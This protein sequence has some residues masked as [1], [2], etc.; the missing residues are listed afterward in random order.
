MAAGGA[1]ALA[2]CQPPRPPMLC[3]NRGGRAGSSSSS[4]RSY[5][6]A[7]WRRSKPWVGQLPPGWPAVRRSNKSRR[8]STKCT[9][10]ASTAA[11]SYTAAGRGPRELILIPQGWVEVFWDWLDVAAMAGAMLGSLMALITRQVAYMAAPLVLSLV[12]LVSA[13]RRALQEW[14]QQR[15][16][17]VAMAALRSEVAA[18]RG[19]GTPTTDIVQWQS[20]EQL[21][22]LEQSSAAAE[23]GAQAAAAASSQM[24][25]SLQALNDSLSQ[26]QTVLGERI[27]RSTSELQQM[28]RSEL[29]GAMTLER[30]TLEPLVTI[31]PKLDSQIAEIRAIVMGLDE[32]RG[33]QAGWLG[34][35]LRAAMRGTE[36]TIAQAVVDE[37]QTALEPAIGMTQTIERVRGD[38]SSSLKRL[39]DELPEMIAFHLNSTLVD[40]M[41]ERL[42]PALAS[43]Q[44]DGV[45]RAAAMLAAQLVDLQRFI[46]RSA[47]QTESTLLEAVDRQAGLLEDAAGSG[48]SVSDPRLFTSLAQQLS[49]LGASLTNLQLQLDAR[50]ESA[51]VTAD[52]QVLTT[53]TQQVSMLDASVKTLQSQLD[54]RVEPALV[55]AAE[56]LEEQAEALA[57][58][59]PSTPAVSVADGL[60]TAVQQLSQQLE[61]LQLQQSM[62][63]ALPVTSQQVEVSPIISPAEL[64]NEPRRDTEVPIVLPAIEMDNE[65]Q[66]MLK[67]GAALLSTGQAAMS[68]ASSLSVADRDLSEALQLFSQASE[69][70]PDSVKALGQWGNTLLAIGQLKVALV[71]KLKRANLPPDEAETVFDDIFALQCEAEENLVLAGRKYRAALVL[72]STDARPYY[73][74]GLALCVRAKLVDAERTQ[75][76]EKLYSAAEEKFQAALAVN[77]K[78]V[79][80]HINWGVTLREHAR[81]YT[82]GTDKRAQ[83]LELCVLQFQAVLDIDPNNEVAANGLLRA[84]Q[85]LEDCMT[86]L[87]AVEK[88]TLTR[89]PPRASPGQSLRTSRPSRRRG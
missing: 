24:R 86:A 60:L 19:S 61:S 54:Q 83:L 47:Q 28:M 50:A 79:S 7:C 88:R 14:S 32:E 34:A 16:H 27:T 22:R 49:M 5:P 25:N 8:H 65:L 41:V 53:L 59:V 73:N 26:V 55:A 67:R 30:R 37:V 12:V 48:V 69:K 6:T 87:A 35:H 9:A 13:R 63:D 51:P 29:E 45:A 42:Q 56:R 3:G 85:E 39:Q 21:M 2:A 11:G 64:L 62:Q 46:H 80:A 57:R 23:R 17:A 72:D 33:D 78:M 71:E 76:A 10:A 68:S 4:S 20:D 81:L 70:F 77:P 52:S 1:A 89:S 36:T 84:N 43:S 66:R 82:E 15:E 74:W 44:S 58:A 38:M 40:D 75:D 18:L 31:I